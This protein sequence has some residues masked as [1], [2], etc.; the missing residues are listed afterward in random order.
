MIK[1]ANN[2]QDNVPKNLS[3]PI[4]ANSRKRETE[5][6]VDSAS[7]SNHKRV[8]VDQ[9]EVSEKADEGMRSGE[10]PKAATAAIEPNQR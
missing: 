5:G 7:F 6:R 8:R 9:G 3:L 1:M 2:T 10:S 4:K